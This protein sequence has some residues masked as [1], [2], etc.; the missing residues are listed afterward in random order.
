MSKPPQIALL[1]PY[2]VLRGVPFSFHERQEV[3]HILILKFP[4]VILLPICI[5]SVYDI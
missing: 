1:T 3:R 2:T 4:A 5:L